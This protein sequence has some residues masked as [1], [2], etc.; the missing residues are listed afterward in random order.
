MR[1]HALQLLSLT[2][3]V[4]ACGSVEAQSPV[5]V[6]ARRRLAWME[7]AIAECRLQSKEIP[8]AGLKFSEK[9]LL[10]YDDPT[11]GMGESTDGL[12]DATVWRL[13]KS[14]RP[15]ALVMLEFYRRGA[16]RA[17]VSYEFLSLVPSP[18]ELTSPNGPTW[19]PSGTDLKMS[20]LEGAPPPADSPRTRLIQM[21]QLA[22]RF[23]VHED[24]NDSK[25][26]CRLLAQPIDRYAGE[27]DGTVDGAI[28]AF[29]NGT[30]PEVGLLL[31]C[32]EKEWSFGL[33]RLSAAA[34]YVKLDDKQIWEAAKVKQS[35]ALDSYAG[36]AYTIEWKE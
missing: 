15:T 14:G 31:E 32:R 16:G 26:E 8:A 9:P 10:R 7:Q 2:A 34:L 12:E 25:I 1:K 36:M 13:G 22:R 3:A 35:G 19:T 27:P 11:R 18:L 4:V 20:S 29:A 6:A 24:V 28:F 5:G 30:N 17:V 21:R 23:S 33:C